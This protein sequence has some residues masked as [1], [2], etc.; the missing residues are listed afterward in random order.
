M[1]QP[2]HAHRPKAASRGI[3]KP[4]SGPPPIVRQLAFRNSQAQSRV[5]SDE[6]A[7]LLVSAPGPSQ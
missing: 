3:A 2:T 6:L 7:K 1:K 4:D 5:L